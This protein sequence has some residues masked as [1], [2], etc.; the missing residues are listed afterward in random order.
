MSGH[1][2]AHRIK[3][4]L[5]PRAIFGT[6]LEL[7]TIRDQQNVLCPFHDDTIPSLSVNLAKGGSVIDFWILRHGVD[8]R[9]ACD[10]IWSRF[11]DAKRQPGATD[12][13]SPNGSAGTGDRTVA[14]EVLQRYHEALLS[15]AHAE[16]LRGL[17][18][19]RGWTT[20]TVRQ[21]QIGWN[22][23]RYTI[24]VIDSDGR[25]RNIRLYHP[26]P[27]DGESKFHSYGTG[28]GGAT[29]FNEAAL[30]HD[31]VLVVEGEP[32]VIT[33]DQYGFANAVTTTVG[34][35]VWREEFSEQLRDKRV[36]VIYDIDDAGRAGA[37]K[38]VDALEDTASS[39]HAVDL[40]LDPDK[41]PHGDLSDFLRERGA[42]ALHDLIAAVAPARGEV[43]ISTDMEAVLDAAEAA[44]LACRAG[45]YQRAGQL[46]RARDGQAAARPGVSRD[47]GMAVIEQAPAA[48]LR[49][50]M[51][52]AARWF[53]HKD[54]KAKEKLPPSWAVD[55]LIARGAWPFPHL[56][57]I[58]HSPCLR[59]DNTLL[60][61]PGYDNATGLY[62]CAGARIDAIPSN[63]TKEDASAA[64]KALWEP[65]QD[66]P[67]AGDAEDGSQTEGWAATIAAI[68]TVLC[69]YAIDGAMPMFVVTAPV[70]GSGKTRF[71]DVVSLITTGHAAT[72]AIP[73]SNEDEERKRL[74]SLCLANDPIILIDN[75]EKPLKSATLAAALTSRQI[76]DRVLGASEM[77]TAPM[78]GVW[79]GTGNN[80]QVRGDLSRRIVL[81]ELDPG[82]E[83]PEEREG[84]QHPDLLQWTR[85]ER[86]RLV[87]AALTV[88][89]AFVAAGR[90]Q[91]DLTPYGSFEEWSSTVRACVKWATGID[92]LGSRDRLRADA[93]L[94]HG[95]L[96]VALEVWE[97]AFGAGDENAKTLREIADWCADH[98][99]SPLGE[100]LKELYDHRGDAVI[101]TKKLGYALRNH[102]GRIFDGRQLQRGGHTKG[103]R[104]WWVHNTGETDQ[105]DEDPS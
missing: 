9:T 96:R 66:F 18:G 53:E 6:C 35:S 1:G 57:G 102:S 25:C 79:F 19:R 54:G 58:V 37:R 82:M 23:S 103:G 76:R 41:H 26:D 21:W 71:V 104:P 60:T 100:A 62:H 72:R 101:N 12:S 24:P 68:L 38:V 52:S 70:R 27:P 33:A 93:D 28:Y 50:R 5:D 97:D 49:E 22:G 85:R 84:F 46:V 31:M 99:P 7:G 39:V 91:D 80:V 77:V 63:P 83:F 44:L 13:S 89:R 81:I 2:H 16:G 59:P 105:L 8:F 88:L 90:P 17:L 95:A 42:D 64:L 36:V 65:F 15:A 75:I 14:I 56:C 69:R 51:S 48:W 67:F 40:P 78:D 10:E 20:E 86:P 73:A 4:E 87:T 32:D 45:I 43:T 30:D 92:P 61:A 11:Y 74:V 47:A 94:E 34:A 29:L 3:A 55:G 98:E